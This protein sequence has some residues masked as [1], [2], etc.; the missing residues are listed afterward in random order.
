MHEFL[1][2]SLF[3]YH[4]DLLDD[5]ER[6]WEETIADD[7]ETEL[8]AR[9]GGLTRVNVDQKLLLDVQVLLSRLVGKAEQL[10]GNATT[11]LA[12]SWMNI[13]AKFDGGKFYN[14]S[15]SGSWD[16]RCMGAGL[17]QNLGRDW[18]PQAWRQMTGT[19]PNNVFTDVA[20]HSANVCTKDRKR[21]ATSEVKDKRRRSKYANVDDTS[22]ARKSYNR[23][24]GG[25]SP[26]EVVDDLS[27]EDLDELK[28]S[29]FKANV[30]VTQEEA[31]EIERCTR[32]QAND[33]DWISERRKRLTASS[34]GG[35]AKMRESTK[36]GKKVQALLYNTFGGNIAT[37]YGTS[38]EDKAKCEYIAYKHRNGHSHLAVEECG[39]F[40]SRHNNWLAATPDGMVHD[41]HS[42]SETVGLLEIKCPYSCRDLYLGEACEKTSFCLTLNEKK[43]LKLKNRHDYWYQV[44]CQLYCVDKTWCDF[45][46][47]TNKELHVERIYRD[48]KWW[49]LQLAKLRKF[50][51]SSLLPE[52][53]C[54]RFRY[55]GIRE[56]TEAVQNT[57]T[58]S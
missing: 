48:A 50:Y 43:E 21:K 23:R 52:L 28:S 31:D 42:Q 20:T 4:T 1:Y 10:L 24:D 54:P 22:A 13:R 5:Q 53:A 11:N 34:V 2:A 44:Q 51:F 6:L 41:P 55:G 8:D 36:K 16:H 45:V 19:S 47:R 38:M 35:I 26:E 49:G 14:R 29:Y 15:Q 7:P 18:G 12:E 9:R 3:I 46:V 57:N 17:R 32:S 40:I 37:N 27:H 56:P 58:S 25:T 30:C 39:L 33:Q